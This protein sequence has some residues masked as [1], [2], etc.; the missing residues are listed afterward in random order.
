MPDLR[1]TLINSRGALR[2]LSAV[3]AAGLLAACGDPT[4]P[5][6][7]RGSICDFQQGAF[8][9]TLIATNQE[10]LRHSWRGWHRRAAGPCP[11]SPPGHRMDDGGEYRYADDGLR[12]T[13]PDGAPVALQDAAWP[14]FI[15]MDFR[16][17]WSGLTIE[18]MYVPGYPLYAYGL[19]ADGSVWR[20][21]LDAYG[22]AVESAA[23]AHLDSG[24]TPVAIH[25]PRHRLVA[26]L[27][28]NGTDRRV[29]R[30][31]SE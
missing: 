11:E 12:Y 1:A 13:A 7:W 4:P 24:W 9:G 29:F 31:R 15:H 18:G 26:V 25:V 20:I 17:S 14:R 5:P 3:L 23:L 19:G 27:A 2:S 6:E 16:R 8:R 10:T 21:R 22:Q 28:S 30:F